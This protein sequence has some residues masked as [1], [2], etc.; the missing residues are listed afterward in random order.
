LSAVLPASA[1]PRDEEAA[2]VDR[3]LA[4]TVAPSAT[5]RLVA[6]RARLRAALMDIA[7]PP[8]RPSAFD[9]LGGLKAQ[10]LDR[11]RSL[12]GAT[13]IIESLEGWWAQHPL[14]AASIVA[15]EASRSFILPVARKNPLALVV[16]SLVVGALLVVAKPWKW[17]LRPALFVGLLPQLASHALQRMPIEGWLQMLNSIL[18]SKRASKGDAAAD[19]APD[20][21]TPS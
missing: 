19:P 10:L 5:E 14:H 9:G 17:L 8:P 12:P 18:P 13:L 3:A 16:A 2:A 7:H 11:V 4:S 20:L 6:S 1:A 21:P 15:E